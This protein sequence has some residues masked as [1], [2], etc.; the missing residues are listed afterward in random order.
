MTKVLRHDDPM[1]QAMQRQAI[2]FLIG[3]LLFGSAAGVIF[4]GLL[5]WTDAAGLATMIF[6]SP[7]WAL[8]LG[9]L[10]FG[11]FITFGSIGM[12]VGIMN[13]GE[14]RD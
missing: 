8:A 1:M 9:L 14:E 13:L 12:A 11:L 4:G 6:A 5:L 3:H 7:D 2:R 10:F